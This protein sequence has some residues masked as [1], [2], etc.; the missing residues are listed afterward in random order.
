MLI[1][2]R[3]ICYVYVYISAFSNQ[4]VLI[5]VNFAFS[6]HEYL[7]SAHCHHPSLL[8]PAPPTDGAVVHFSVYFSLLQRQKLTVSPN[9]QSPKIS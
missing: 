9:C 6:R 2:A 8:F 4:F 1:L 5:E 7:L 3:R